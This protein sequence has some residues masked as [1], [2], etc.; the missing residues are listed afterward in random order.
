MDAKTQKEIQDL[1]DKIK[2]LEDILSGMKPDIK[3]S[4]VI[5]DS[6]ILR[7]TRQSST[8]PDSEMER[9]VS[10]NGEGQTIYVMRYPDA[11]FQIKDKFGN[12]FQVP[13]YNINII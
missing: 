4:N 2:S 8:T 12:T 11:F 1:K 13:A 6:V 7:T 3:L 9:A 5:R 10:L